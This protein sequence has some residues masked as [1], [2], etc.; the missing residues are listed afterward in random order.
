[1]KKYTQEQKIKIVELRKNGF[2][3]KDIAIT[4]GI[5]NLTTIRNVCTQAGLS[6]RIYKPRRKYLSGQRYGN[7]VLIK[8]GF[9]K[10]AK[11]GSPIPYWECK[12]DC[13]KIFFVASKHMRT[14]LKSCGCLSKSNRF[15]TCDSKHVIGNCRYNHYKQGAIRRNLSWEL[16]LDQFIELI[17]SNCYYCNLEP[18]LLVKSGKHKLKT[19]GIDRVNTNIGYI[20]DNCVACCK[21]CNFAK[22]NSNLKDFLNWIYRLRLKNENCSNF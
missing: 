19:N 2:L 10:K 16:S 14:R 11:D 17:F 1:M 7:F 18:F 21:F 12:C 3:L 4:L 8:I 9:N 6:K 15:K 22:G 5:N 13:G 20:I